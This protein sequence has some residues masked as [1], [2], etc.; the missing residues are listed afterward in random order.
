MKSIKQYLKDLKKDNQAVLGMQD[1]KQVMLFL[2]TLGV[3]AIALF[4]A[5]SNLQSA[6]LFGVGSQS[7]NNTNLI[8]N[9]ITGGTTSFFGNVPTIFTVLGAVVIITAVVLIIIAVTRIN[10]ASGFSSQ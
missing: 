5:L 4:L 6:N 8:I 1:V 10:S 2:L 3:V 9:N 7:A